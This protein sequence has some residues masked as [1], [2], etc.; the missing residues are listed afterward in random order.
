[1]TISEK[2]MRGRNGFLFLNGKDSNNLVEHLQGEV[3]V[4]PSAR[5]VHTANREVIAGLNVPFLGI[6]VPEAHCLYPE[7]LPEGMAPPSPDRPVNMVID[8]MAPGYV[9]PIDVLLAYK[10]AGGVVYTGRDSHWTQM[11]ALETYRALRGRLGRTHDFTL[12]YEPSIAAETGDLTM[13][14]REQVIAAERKAQVRSNLGYE[15]L[16]A[17]RVLNHGNVMVLHNPQGQGRA[18]AFGTSFSGR[19]IPA[20]ASDFRELVFCYGTTVDPFM[21]DLVAPDCVICELPERFLHF[22]ALSVRGGTIVG[23]LLGLNDQRNIASALVARPGLVPES[24]RD[25]VGLFGA[26]QDLA[27]GKPAP[28]LLRSLEAIDM[29]LALRVALLAPALALPHSKG[30]L[31]LLLSG[32]F[33]NRGVLRKAFHMIDG[34]E[35]GL[36]ELP[37]IPDSENGLLAKVRLF[38]RAGLPGHAREALTRCIALFGHAPE[39][40]YYEKQL[41]R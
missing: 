7:E 12:A 36:R 20:Y 28:Q 17:S 21:V 26:C 38:I 19:L 35:L 23:L 2:A 16:F 22:P 32:Q 4:Q 18:L 40:E 8:D 24:L 9:Y 39:A 34:Q 37:L 27:T 11:A 5:R 3:A 29:N 31:R 41:K 14:S 10:E 30:G 33:Y 6:I 1:M 25:L 15:N 13:D